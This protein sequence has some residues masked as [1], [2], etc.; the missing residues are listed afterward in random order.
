MG[1]GRPSGWSEARVEGDTILVPKAVAAKVL[2]A[3]ASWLSSLNVP[4][5]RGRLYDLRVLS[6]EFVT[7]RENIVKRRTE[8]AKI[9]SDELMAAKV[10]KTELEAERL[11]LQNRQRRGELVDV[12]HMAPVITRALASFTRR[13]SNIPRKLGAEHGLDREVEEAT[14]LLIDD[15]LREL[16]DM[17]YGVSEVANA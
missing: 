8:R 6:R 1:A 2:G 12:E 4:A 17:D 3:N 16:A 14:K 9:E 5:V 15:A 7:Y 11:E 13:L 10:R